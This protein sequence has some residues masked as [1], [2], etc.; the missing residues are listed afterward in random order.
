MKQLIELAATMVAV[1][2]GLVAYCIAMALGFIMWAV[3]VVI[4]LWL[5]VHISRALGLI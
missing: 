4:G 3:P 1:V 5:M 2:F